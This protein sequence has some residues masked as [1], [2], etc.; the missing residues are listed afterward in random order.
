[1][2]LVV[3]PLLNAKVHAPNAVT[4][5]AMFVVAPAHIAA[6]WVVIAATGR[7]FKVMAVLPVSPALIAEH[8]LS[9]NEVRE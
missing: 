7:V 6:F 2:P 5:P 3:V 1:M 8:L 4:F 9:V